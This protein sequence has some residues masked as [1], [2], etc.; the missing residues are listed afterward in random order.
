MAVDSPDT[1]KALPRSVCI[2]CGT[3]CTK[4]GPALHKQ[5][6]EIIRRGVIMPQH[7]FSLRKGEKVFENVKAAVV[8]LAEEMIKIKGK[9]GSWT[10]MFFDDKSKQCAIYEN[11]PL[12]CRALACWDTSAIEAIYTKD[13]MTRHDLIGPKDAV[14][15]FM[16]AHEEKCSHSELARLTALLSTDDV[17]QS[18]N[19]ILDM[20]LY[21]NDMRA[22]L[23]EKAGLQNDYLDFL[24]GRPM[25]EALKGYRLEVRNIRGKLTLMPL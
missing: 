11:R 7:L 4:G 8:P 2:Q 21:E 22:M 17:D 25:G 14:H 3:C 12:E 15:K 20:I 24:F 6:M 1:G 23:V 13:R 10:C 5:D 16:D 19:R 9:P 18:A